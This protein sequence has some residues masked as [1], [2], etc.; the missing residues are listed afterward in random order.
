M[1]FTLRFPGYLP[2][3]L[4]PSPVGGK[5]TVEVGCQHR[6]GHL[7]DGTYAHHPIESLAQSCRVYHISSLR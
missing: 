3:Q 7:R 1:H 4:C 6:Q 2:L 5:V